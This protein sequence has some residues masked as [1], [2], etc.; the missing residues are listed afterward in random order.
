MKEGVSALEHEF[1]ESGCATIGEYLASQ[2]KKR[3][4]PDHY[5]RT[6]LRSLLEEE[7]RFLLETQRTH[8]F[9]GITK[10]IEEL[11]VETM[12][13]Q[14]PLRSSEN[15]VGVCVLT[16]EQR[17]VRAAPSVLKFNLLQKLNNTHFSLPGEKRS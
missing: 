6:V 15:L 12:F 13:S 1:R 4:S 11:I 9:S 8:G 14:L 10:E 7:V 16:G 2:P 5:E 3:N 17:A